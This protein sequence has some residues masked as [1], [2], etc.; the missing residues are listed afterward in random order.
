MNNIINIT[1]P[2][3]PIAK[4]R[5]RKGAHGNWYNPQEDIMYEVKK[6]IKKQLPDGWE[7]IKSGVPVKC[8]LIFFFELPKSIL[9]SKKKIELFKNDDKPCL[10]KKDVDN[11]IKFIW[12]CMNKI[13]WHDDNQVYSTLTEKYYSINPRTE[14]EVIF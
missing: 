8:N 4:Q 7:I 11:L 6:E 2:G 12:D 10:N 9:N 13:V 14:I 5:S 3:Q 1:I